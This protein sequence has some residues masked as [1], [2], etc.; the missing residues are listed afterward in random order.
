MAFF[1]IAKVFKEGRQKFFVWTQN[2]TV[3]LFFPQ[4]LKTVRFS[5]VKGKLRQF[6]KGETEIKAGNALAEEV[7]CIKDTFLIA[8]G[9]Q[10]FFCSV[11]NNNNRDLKPI[12]K[13]ENQREYSPI[14][15][16]DLFTHPVSYDLMRSPYI[17]MKCRFLV[18][19]RVGLF[20]ILD[21]GDKGLSIAR[22][23]R[24]TLVTLYFEQCPKLMETPC[25]DTTIQKFFGMKLTLILISQEL[26]MLIMM[27]HDD[28]LILT[29]IHYVIS[30]T[31]CKKVNTIKKEI[32]R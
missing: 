10:S 24:H 11:H 22:D 29:Q 3:A 30:I 15:L 31:S 7:F 5:S 16:R 32:I 2:V 25:I 18:H 19:T 17:D 13:L 1:Q 28:I 4:Q 6:L 12:S 26:L 14:F 20:H 27:I 8:R 21:T 9:E 23:L